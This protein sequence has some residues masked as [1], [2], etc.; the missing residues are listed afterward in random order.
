LIETQ[1]DLNRSSKIEQQETVVEN[2]FKS[3][4]QINEKDDV[5]IIKTRSDTIKKNIQII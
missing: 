4:H 5:A 2:F 1:A 3:I